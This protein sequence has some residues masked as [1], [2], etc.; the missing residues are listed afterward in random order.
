[1]EKIARMHSDSTQPLFPDVL[2]LTG[3]GRSGTSYL[4]EALYECLDFGFSSEPKFI[5]DMARRAHRYGDL[6]EQKNFDS[7]IQDV[8]QSR[9]LTLL[10][11]R[12]GYQH[13]LDE[14]REQF[15]EQSYRG[16]VYA[17]LALV[18][19]TRGKSRLAYKDPLDI[20]NLKLIG[21]LLPTSRF[22]HIL[23]DPRDVSLSM[24][25]FDWGTTNMY[26]GGW[27]WARDISTARSQAADLSDRYH[28]VRY[29]DLILN[30]E[31]TV[32]KMID[33]LGDEF[34]ER[35]EN[36]L[37]NYINRTKDSRRIYQWEAATDSRAIARCES[38][39]GQLLSK[40]NYRRTTGT[41][42]GAICGSVYLIADVILRAL[43]KFRRKFQFIRVGR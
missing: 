24:K 39:A 21:N 19:K 14:F 7:L 3:T 23:R 12:L 8:Y 2:V 38:G 33:F 10:K 41:E 6:T 11:T 9:L 37:T 17:A 42:T 26:A 32:K 30:T 20:R 27:H 29:E 43:R 40:L 31:E 13:T 28:E 18:A 15:I 5:A 4:A 36:S 1:M 22:I 34:D 35:H 25:K 16:S